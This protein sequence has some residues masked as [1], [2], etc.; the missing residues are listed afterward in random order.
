MN[1]EALV[2]DRQVVIC[3]GTGGVGKTTTA[4]VLA[5]EGAR[6]GRRACVVTIDPAKRLQSAL[7][8]TLPDLEVRVPGEG[9]SAALL[10]P[11]D[12]LR[13]WAKEACADEA[14]RGRLG[15]G[16]LGL[17]RAARARQHQG[18]DGD[19]DARGPDDPGYRHRVTGTRARWPARRCRS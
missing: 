13:R 15:S 6:R 12:C 14:R 11:A 18:G 7:G 19:A 8:L 3:C 4:A 1:L 9:L 2:T 10:R 17:R 16:R 5:L